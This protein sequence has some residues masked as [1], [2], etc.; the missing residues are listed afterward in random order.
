MNTVPETTF[1]TRVRNEAIAGPN[2]FEWKDLTTDDIF[3]GKRVVLFA[4]PG[5]FTPTCSTSHLPRY[6]EL[7]EDEEIDDDGVLD[8]DEDFADEATEEPAPVEE[9]LSQKEQNARSLAI[10]RAIEQREEQK[11]LDEDLDYLDLE[12]E[13]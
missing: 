5:A 12:A 3:K 4:L 11:R 10:R 2:P 9:E 13:E 1:R 8:E 6:E 7:S